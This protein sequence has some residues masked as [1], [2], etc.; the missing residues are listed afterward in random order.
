MWS[1]YQFPTSIPL[2]EAMSWID[3]SQSTKDNKVKMEVI[4]ATTCWFIWKFRNNV[5]FNSRSMRKSDIFDNIRLFSYF[6]LKFRTL[7]FVSWNDWLQ[8]PL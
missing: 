4:A 1:G 2:T 5:V 7:L 6:W 3:N 8:H